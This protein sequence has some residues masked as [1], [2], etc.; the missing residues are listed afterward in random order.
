MCLITAVIFTS[1]QANVFN[2]DSKNS[3][4]EELDCNE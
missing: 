3:F 1:E 4:A 2:V